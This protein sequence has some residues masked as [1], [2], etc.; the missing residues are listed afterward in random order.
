MAGPR[1]GWSQSAMATGTLRPAVRG[2][3]HAPHHDECH[4]R[5]DHQRQVRALN[6]EVTRNVRHRC[7]RPSLTTTSS[8]PWSGSLIARNRARYPTA[9]EVDRYRAGD[10]IN[11]LADRFRSNRTTVIPHLNRQGVERR[12]VAKQWDHKTLASAARSYADGSSLAHI[13]A[14]LGLDPSTV[15]NR[16]RRAGIPP[17]VMRSANWSVNLTRPDRDLETAY[18]RVFLFG[19]SFG[20]NAGMWPKSHEVGPRGPCPARERPL[21]A[22]RGRP[23][24]PH[25][26]ALWD[27]RSGADASLTSTE[28]STWLVSLFDVGRVG[29]REVGATRQ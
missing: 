26:R 21:S 12:A 7:G 24:G 19:V 8:N 1:W 14:Q 22:H 23:R 28:R 10:T 5:P 27:A 4:S 2:S 13:A 9:T 29:L 20:R 18:G 6:L 17:R 16:F 11:D 25:R 15:A 3:P